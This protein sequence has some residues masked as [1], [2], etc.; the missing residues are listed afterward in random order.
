MGIKITPADQWFAKCVK[1]R[2]DWTCEYSNKY[3]PEGDRRG[4]ECSH[5]FSRRHYSIRFDPRNAFAHSTHSHFHLGGN[6][7]LFSRWAEEQLGSGC[8]E[9]LI[10]KKNDTNLAKLVKKNLK[11][12]AKHYKQEYERMR[13]LRAEGVT[14]RIEFAGYS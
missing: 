12:V 1:E 9:R 8:I 3:F 10:E 2:A 6:P 11:D 5:L 7:V 13:Q 14:G 4:I